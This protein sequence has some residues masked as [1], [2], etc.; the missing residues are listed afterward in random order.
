MTQA[1]LAMLMLFSDL[2]SREDRQFAWSA[3]QGEDMSCGFSTL[4][5][6]LSGY[7]GLEA[8][9]SYLIGKY[10]GRGTVSVKDLLAVLSGEGF[11]ARAYRMDFGE[12]EL[13]LSRA[14]P[15]IVH[16]DRPD[17]HFSLILDIADDCVVASDPALGT[18]A[19]YKEDFLR[20]WSGAV[21]VARPRISAPAAIRG[22]AFSRADKGLLAAAAD[23]A[24]GRLRG[25]DDA[26][27]LERFARS[28]R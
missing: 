3:E 13:A 23:S 9:E 10:G 16:H 27:R 20:T 22:P 2:V 24:R 8:P 5:T 26:R 6:F 12:L 17:G 15:L 14:A 21:I 4:A 19:S 18:L 1:V 25:I 7:W 28:M 11:E